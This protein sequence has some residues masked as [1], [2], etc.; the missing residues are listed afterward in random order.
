MSF[1]VVIA[2]T[3]TDIGKTVFAAGLT[4]ALGGSYWKPIQAGLDGE[5]DAQCVQRLADL[6]ASRIVPEV[7]RLKTPASPHLAAEIDGV[8]IAIAKL[9]PPA[10]RLPLVIE[11]AGGLAVPLTRRD[12]QIDV[13][14]R[15]QLPV[16]LCASTRL[17]T[18]NHSLLSI[19][20]LKQRAIPILGVAFIGDENIDSQRTI[21]AFGGVKFLGRLPRLDPL[22]PQSL[23]GAFSSAFRVSDILGLSEAGP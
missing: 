20:A 13:V 11:L 14:A 15:W 3:D 16:I 9:T 1:Q 8:E 5:T 2:G 7:Y 23:Q 10:T 6:D 12:L 17:G 4:A 21:S 18:I 22:T 19:Q